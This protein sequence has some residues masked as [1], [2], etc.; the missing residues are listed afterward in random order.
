MLCW[1]KSSTFCVQ[2]ID[3]DPDKGLEHLQTLEDMLDNAPEYQLSKPQGFMTAK[4]Y[5]TKNYRAAHKQI[6]VAG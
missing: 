5:K 2:S 1:E 3:I 6:K 4:A